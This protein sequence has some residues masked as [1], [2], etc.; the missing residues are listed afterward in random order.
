M[1]FNKDSGLVKIWLSLVLVGTY[2]VDQVPR[3]FNLRDVVAELVG[4]LV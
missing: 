3:L 4:N 2:T 1:N